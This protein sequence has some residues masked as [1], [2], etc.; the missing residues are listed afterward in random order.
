MV[1]TLL[2]LDPD[3]SKE[4]MGYAVG[5]NP[6]AQMLFS[7]L[8]GWWANR[9]GSIRQPLL[10]T[11]A[12]FTASSA[13]YAALEVLPVHA[14]K[15]AML[16]SRFLVGV[17][18]GQLSVACWEG[19]QLTRKSKDRICSNPSLQQRKKIILDVILAPLLKLP[20]STET[21]LG[22]CPY[23][24]FPKKKYSKIFLYP[25]YLGLVV[26]GSEVVCFLS[27][28]SN[29]TD[30]VVIHSSLQPTSPPAAPTYPPPPG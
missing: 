19:K 27:A 17:S 21:R 3:A 23:M 2:Q 16:I 4:F 8:V 15:H 13:A 14:R 5:A 30:V 25:I 7:P 6:F 10:F 20:G 24:T 12:L 1:W 26:P 9:S 11:T 28:K 18:S 22:P 29:L